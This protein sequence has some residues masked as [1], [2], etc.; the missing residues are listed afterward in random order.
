GKAAES[1]R[2]RAAKLAAPL[3]FVTFV[4]RGFQPLIMKSMSAFGG[5]VSWL[6]GFAIVSEGTTGVFGREALVRMGRT[7]VLAAERSSAGSAPALRGGGA[8][9]R[10]SSRQ[11]GV[12]R[13]LAPASEELRVEAEAAAAHQDQAEEDHA[14]LDRV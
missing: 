2:L 6:A 14:H 11:G 9:V 13:S 3:T 10:G 12:G 5:V 8:F 7:L 1:A 4:F